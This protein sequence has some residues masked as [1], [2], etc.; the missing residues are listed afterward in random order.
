MPK[1]VATPTWYVVIGRWNDQEDQALCVTATSP[2]RAAAAF[3]QLL[4]DEGDEEY[5]EDSNPIWVTYVIRCGSTKPTV[6]YDP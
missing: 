4:K 6:S 1:R 3:K 2:A 5:D